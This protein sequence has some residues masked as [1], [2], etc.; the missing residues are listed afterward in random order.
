MGTISKVLSRFEVFSLSTFV[1]LKV[2][3]YLRYNSRISLAPLL[4]LITLLSLGAIIAGVYQ[5]HHLLSGP[6]QGFLDILKS[7]QAG[8]LWWGF[9]LMYPF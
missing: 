5:L 7:L 4:A 1:T 9:Q 8:L 6:A 3:V 2:Y